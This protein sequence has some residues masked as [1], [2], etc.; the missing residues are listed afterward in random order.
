MTKESA[1]TSIAHIIYHTRQTLGK[2][3]IVIILIISNN[4]RKPFKNIGNRLI[5]ISPPPLLL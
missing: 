1:C 4:Y 2:S 5:L 3:E